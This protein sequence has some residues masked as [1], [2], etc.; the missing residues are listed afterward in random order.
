MIALL[1]ALDRS[2]DLLLRVLT[3]ATSMAIT[4]ALAA[5]VICR[6]FFGVSLVGMHEAS[7]FAAMWLYMCGAMLASRRGEHLVV[8]ILANS[9]ATR[10]GR[11]WHSLFLACLTLAIA[12]FFAF[13][14]WKMFAWGARRPQIIPVLDLPL[15]TAQVPFAMAALAGI[16]YAARD[17]VRAVIQIRNHQI[18]DHGEER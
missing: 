16:A 11:A 5:L 14:V 17:I 12:G 18:G 6:Y 10:A 2:F 8:D 7:L 13:W 3:I 4:L 9:F 15:W 1:S